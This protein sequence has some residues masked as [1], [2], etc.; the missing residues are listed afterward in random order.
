MLL[1]YWSLRRYG[2]RPVIPATT[3]LAEKL[4]FF[5]IAGCGSLPRHHLEGSLHA[6]LLKDRDQGPPSMT[7][8]LLRFLPRIKIPAPM[9]LAARVTAMIFLPKLKGLGTSM[10]GK[11]VKKIVSSD[12]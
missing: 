5:A 12:T 4:P 7:P 1:D 10:I 6:R 3:L 8:P 11:M 2:P 9:A